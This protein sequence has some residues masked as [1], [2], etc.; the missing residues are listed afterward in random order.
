MSNRINRIIW[1]K[2]RIEKDLDI[3]CKS[4]NELDK[5]IKMLESKAYENSAIHLL[6]NC[7]GVDVN[8]IDI[9]EM[10]CGEC[11]DY[12]I[13]TSSGSVEIN[14]EY[15]T[16]SS[17]EEYEEYIEENEIDNAPCWWDFSDENEI[18]WNIF[19]NYNNNDIDLNVAN[20]IG[21]PVIRL[22]NGDT[23]VSIAGCGMD[24]S[25]HLMEYQALALGRLEDKFANKD[26]LEWA[27]MNMTTEDFKNMIEH[28]GVSIDRID[29]NYYNKR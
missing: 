26:K 17:R 24:L 2:N 20:K 9:S 29:N 19:Y 3:N 23:Y 27:K 12:E 8:V 15:L 14:D 4:Y 6:I 7:G 11:E 21:L 1:E 16:F 10:E 18:Y 28:L 13:I 22:R 5:E 25:F